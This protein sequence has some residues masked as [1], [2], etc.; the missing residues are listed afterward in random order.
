[1]IMDRIYCYEYNIEDLQKL[2]T[3]QLLNLLRGIR[4][5]NWECE[6][7]KNKICNK[8]RD[9]IKQLLS[10]RPHIM[11]KKE[12]KEHRKALIKQGK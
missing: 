2:H 1:M 11:N 6:Y 8:N 12:S 4:K 5:G 10:T 7:C 9:I 3:K